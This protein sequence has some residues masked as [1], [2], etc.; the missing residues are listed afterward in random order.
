MINV[1][2]EFAVFNP[3][4]PVTAVCLLSAAVETTFPS[5]SSESIEEL[6]PLSL[7]WTSSSWT[8]CVTLRVLWFEPRNLWP[9]LHLLFLSFSHHTSPWLLWHC[10]WFRSLFSLPS[11]QDSSSSSHS[12][13]YEW[14]SQLR[15]DWTRW[16]A[17]EVLRWW[18]WESS[19]CCGGERPG[20]EP[21]DL[22][23]D[24]DQTPEE[25]VTPAFTWVIVLVLHV[26]QV[27]DTKVQV[28]NLR[29]LFLISSVET[30]DLH[31][32]VQTTEE[33]RNRFHLTTIIVW[34]L[35]KKHFNIYLS[36]MCQK[37]IYVIYLFFNLFAFD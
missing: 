28:L 26:Q 36:L 29:K 4:T 23:E 6:C 25:D 33:F 21:E 7:Y 1:G 31:G 37:Y 11:W 18:R 24:G 15:M 2:G 30:S 22:P 3:S 20:W 8:S 17:A 34:F 13:L 35:V 16:A 19:G 27:K 32:I 12:L 10:V 9:H 5:L 14:L